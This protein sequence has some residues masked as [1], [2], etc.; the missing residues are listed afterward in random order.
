MKRIIPV[1]LLAVAVLRLPIAAQPAAAYIRANQIGY[2]PGD[3]KTAVA[4]SHHAL[5]HASFD[6]IDA[7][8]GRTVFG[9]S[10]LPVNSGAY[11]NF[12]FNYKLD[13][14]AL[15]KEGRYK[16]R[17]TGSTDESL[18][19][20]V[21]P[22]AYNTHH[23]SLLFFMREQRCGYNPFLD[24]VC[25][26]KDGRTAYGPMPDSTYVDVSGGWHDAADQLRYLM[27]SGNAVCRLLFAYEE[28]KGKYRDE[29]N[30]L[31][32]RGANGIPDILDEA[33]WGLDWMLRMHP[34][35]DQL[36]H[37][38]ADDRD[39]MK[40]GLPPNDSSDYGWGLN[41]YRVAYYATGKPQGLRKY[42]NTSDG[43]ANLAGRYAAAM[44]MASRIW[45][46]DL[47]DPAYAAQCLKAGREV[48]DMGLRQPGCQE[49]VPCIS[50][51]RYMERT[52]ADDMEWGAAELYAV[53]H[54]KK[55]LND[56]K[57]FARLISTT[58]WMGK[59]TSG[60]YEM[61]PFMNLGHYAMWK[62]ADKKFKDTLAGYY[63]TGIDAVWRKASANAFEMGVPFIWCSFNLVVDFT[64]Q[65]I[66]YKKM[67][68][69][70]SYDHL[71]YAC[72]DWLLGRNPWGISA[73]V[74]IPADGNYPRYPH[75]TVAWTTGRPI[76]GAL[77]DGPVFG[78]IF[79]YLSGVA[80]SR[81]DPY[82]EFQSDLVV[83]HDDAADY[84]TNEPI[85]DGTAGAAFLLA[86]YA[87]DAIA[88]PRIPKK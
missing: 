32:Q 12:A 50:P 86:W 26:K 36:F 3:V 72:R 80:L 63:R 58:S 70:K 28:N 31:G 74:G 45:T 11:A 56:G 19:F 20:T 34:A 82:A 54:E 38:V 1:I 76:T 2:L 64:T 16:V 51:Y 5:E 37:Q 10:P 83:Y 75:N 67:T 35:P 59:D 41:S 85:M 42:K 53:T 33:K 30:A 78:S 23:E 15:K 14:T 79:K 24:E 18:P 55:Y 9:P 8:S 84:S 60:H 21:G 69:D 61:F 40:G 22:N 66:L 57:K 47:G 65:C 81:P 88:V 62:V 52:W 43:L 7:V 73:F 44:A 68:G 25:H 13:F 77:N 48:Y 17:L 87:N 39:H 46:V 29:Y 27:T 6:V 49:G 71:Q 4:F